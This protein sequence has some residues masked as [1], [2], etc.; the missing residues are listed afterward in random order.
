M[1]KKGYIITLQEEKARLEKENDELRKQLEGE[2]VIQP[3]VKTP[4][5]DYRDEEVTVVYGPNRQ[6]LQSFKMTLQQAFDTLVEY[7]SGFELST[8]R[9][10]PKAWAD[11]KTGDAQNVNSQTVYAKLTFRDRVS[12][13]IES[14]IRDMP[15]WIAVDNIVQQGK[16]GELI[17]EE[18]FLSWYK[19]QQK[20][21]LAN[22]ATF[23]NM[24]KQK[25]LE[26]VVKREIEREAEEYGSN[27]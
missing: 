1:P 10:V 14:I 15:L 3:I 26:A 11:P 6:N 22:D 17:S 24:L 9:N 5:K 23:R 8:N 18:E 12:K 7:Y 4:E 16:E 27:V 13:K 2:K 19:D 25:K 21:D 20:K